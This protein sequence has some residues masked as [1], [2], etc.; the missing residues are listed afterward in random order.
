M[1]SL[2]KKDNYINNKLPIVATEFK[3]KSDLFYV[4]NYISTGNE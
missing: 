2:Y 4:D 3:T 1:S